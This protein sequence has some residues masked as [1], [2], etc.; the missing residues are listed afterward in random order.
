MMYVRT[1]VEP[2]AMYDAELTAGELQRERP[3]KV[4]EKLL[5]VSKATPVTDDH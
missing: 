3:R 1:V 4:W 5:S 2:K